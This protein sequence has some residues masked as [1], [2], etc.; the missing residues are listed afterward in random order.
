MFFSPFPISSPPARYG[1]GYP[2]LSPSALGEPYS[3]VA[4]RHLLYGS[5][6]YRHRGS[7]PPQS[8]GAHR[9]DER[10]RER[11]TGHLK[12]PLSRRK[13]QRQIILAELLNLWIAPRP[14]LELGYLL[15]RIEKGKGIVNPHRLTNRSLSQGHR[16]QAEQGLFA[17]NR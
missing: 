15:S 9:R 17:D 7:S 14:R 12:P 8:S 4:Q 3:L 1:S 10:G 13:V 5:R 2:G 16:V 6:W 11:V